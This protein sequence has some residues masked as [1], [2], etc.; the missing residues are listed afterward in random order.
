MSTPPVLTVLEEYGLIIYEP[1]ECVVWPKHIAKHCI[2]Q[3]G[4]DDFQAAARAAGYEKDADLK[5]GPEALQLPP[6]VDTPV[7]FLPIHN[8]LACRVNP[9]SCWYVSITRELHAVTHQGGS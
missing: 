8:G 5:L 7:P 9:G 2:N 4:E 1:C 6:F 3:H